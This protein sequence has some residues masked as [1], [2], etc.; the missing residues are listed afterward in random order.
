MKDTPK[1]YTD[2]GGRPT[3]YRAEFNEQARKLCLLGATDK[4]LA[5]FFEVE[6][7]TINEW[8]NKHP[9]FKQALKSGKLIADAKVA[10]A[11]FKRATGFKYDEVTFEKVDA[12]G[13]LEQTNAGAIKSKDAYKKKV[14]TKLV[15]PDTAAASL[16]LRNRQPE[17][18]R[19][20]Q[21]M[22]LDFDSMSEEQLDKI[23]EELL[24]R[25]GNG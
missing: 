12:K 11:L 1:P 7:S 10:K 14:I 16:W 22:K 18:W 24:K 3:A 9:D 23:I 2:Q 8:K 15:V 17:T 21:E 4:Q 19:D 6:E 20:R 13:I 5:D 25:S